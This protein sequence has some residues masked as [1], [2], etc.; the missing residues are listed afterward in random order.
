MTSC[1]SN[2]NY[3]Q[4]NPNNEIKYKYEIQP[5]GQ[6]SIGMM[7]ANDEN[8]FILRSHYDSSNRMFYNYNYIE[9]LDKELM[10]VRT[11]ECTPHFE[12][13][14]ITNIAVS[15]NGG[16]W[17]L[18]TLSSS[19]ENE[20]VY[21]R[22]YA[23][24]D[25]E[26][27]EIETVET[28]GIGLIMI[29][30]DREGRVY[31]YNKYTTS[32][33]ASI[34]LYIID[35]AGELVTKIENTFYLRLKMAELNDGRI[36]LLDYNNQIYEL[37][38]D[39]P[40][41]LYTFHDN[42]FND[43]WAGADNSVFLASIDKNIY[44]FDVDTKKLTNFGI[45]ADSGII[46]LISFS[47]HKVYALSYGSLVELVN[48]DENSEDI[49]NRQ[50]ISIAVYSPEQFFN[51]W[52]VDFNMTNKDFKL[53]ITDYQIYNT[54]NDPYGGIMKLNLE[55]VTGNIPDIFIWGQLA[56]WS[57]FTSTIYSG[58]GLLADMYEFIDKDSEL[59]RDSFIP[60]ILNSLETTNGTVLEL[61][62]E[63]LVS[64]VA[65]SSSDISLEKWTINEFYEELEKHPNAKNVFGSSAIPE[66]LLYMFMINNMDEYVDWTTGTCNFETESFIKLIEF[67]A[68]QT[69][70]DPSKF[71]LQ[72]R[73]IIEGRQFLFGDL[74]SSVSS[75]QKFKGMFN[76]EVTFIGYPTSSGRG[77]SLMISKSISISEYSEH[78]EIC[79]EIIKHFYTEEFQNANVILFPTNIHSME[80]QLAHPEKY[81]ESGASIRW[82]S[83]DGDVYQVEFYDATPEESAQ[84][85]ELIWSLDR[86]YRVE[87]VILNIITEAS[88]HCFYGNQTASETAKI[89]QNR[90]SMYLA[91]LR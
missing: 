20:C 88:M 7:S 60:S 58:S 54:E 85:R 6:N 4:D 24:D 14:H 39:Q 15:K 65:C 34:D 40:V 79:W 38:D 66:S 29:G 8:L 10:P 53:E 69:N 13:G 67:I 27:I 74:V 45:P 57:G 80:D 55:I 30:A 49:D 51:E 81:E 41:S 72:R 78:K 22:Y 44:I 25:T 31:L 3:R 61:P 75:I 52:F 76:D 68:T 23:P 87:P 48:I 62:I 1:S 33:P 86:V 63:F 12:D 64:A 50:V 9:V 11:I 82:H 19:I 17:I 83:Y 5:T 32:R 35:T 28:F 46:D 77:N 56:H 26:Q 47:N 42:S 16:Y 91:E 90:I 18:E 43:I 73:Q 70:D 71:E 36:I 59:N 37:V 84:V 21:L 2:A 89:I